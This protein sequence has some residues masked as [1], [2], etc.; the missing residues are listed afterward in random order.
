MD[1]LALEDCGEKRCD[2]PCNRHAHE[3]VANASDPPSDA[4]ES[5]V[6]GKNATLDADDDRWV[7]EFSHIYCLRREGQL[8]VQT[9]TAILGDR[10]LRKTLIFPGWSSRTACTCFPAP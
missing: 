2:T 9:M 1:R 10:T 7:E 6:E 4:E 3:D 5:V 8:S